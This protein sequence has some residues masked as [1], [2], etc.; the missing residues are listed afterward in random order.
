MDAKYQIIVEAQAHGTGSE[1]ECLV[2]MVT[3]L[4]PLM[5]PDT[6][7]TA[8]AGDHREDNLTELDARAI[9][10]LIAD[11]LMRKRDERFATQG[12][13]QTAPDPLHDK[14]PATAASPALFTPRAFTYDAEA[15]TCVCPAGQSLYRKGQQLATKGH[16][17]PISGSQRRLRAVCAPCAVFTHARENANAAGRLL[18]GQDAGLGRLAHGADATTDRYPGGAGALCA[19]VRDR[20]TGLGN[21]R[22]NKKLDRFTLRGQRKVDG[23]W[24][25]FCL[26][27]HIEKLAHHGYADKAA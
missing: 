23:Q 5:T 17:A 7:L 2:P 27:Q 21:L 18:H 1:Q 8:D 13:H 22:F 4:A 20:G 11:G 25:L 9:D 16:I 24:Q 10:A 3:A 14:T 6:V 15:R 19:A 26:I 12:R